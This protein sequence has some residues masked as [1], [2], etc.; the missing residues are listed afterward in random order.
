MFCVFIL[1][2]NRHLNTLALNY[3]MIARFTSSFKTTTSTL[4]KSL[5][6]SL[7]DKKNLRITDACKFRAGRN[8]NRNFDCRF[9]QSRIYCGVKL[10]RTDIACRRVTTKLKFACLYDGIFSRLSSM[11]KKSEFLTRMFL[12]RQCNVHSRHFTSF[13]SKIFSLKYLNRSFF[14]AIKI[15]LSL[16]L[17]L[18][19]LSFSN[20]FQFPRNVF[21]KFITSRSIR[22]ENIYQFPPQR[23]FAKVTDSKMERANRTNGRIVPKVERHDDSH[24]R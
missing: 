8:R 22:Q 19:S 9:L 13:T 6:S 3:C 7:R 17:S 16:F 21:V 15:R 12:Q 18:F 24:S 5:I 20:H 1:L 4:C 2:C 14:V 10:S 11:L 23:T